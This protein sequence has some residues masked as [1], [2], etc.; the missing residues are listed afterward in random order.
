MKACAG[1]KAELSRFSIAR[2]YRASL[3]SATTLCEATYDT[4]ATSLRATAFKLRPNFNSSAYAPIA[5]SYKNHTN[6][7]RSQQP[8]AARGITGQAPQPNI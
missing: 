4:C 8:S 7:Y 3:H 5:S 1:R 6:E 2:S